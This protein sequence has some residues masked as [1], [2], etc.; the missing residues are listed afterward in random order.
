V[1]YDLKVEKYE[2]TLGESW[3]DNNN[4]KRE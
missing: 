4:E 3:I 2:V 1:E